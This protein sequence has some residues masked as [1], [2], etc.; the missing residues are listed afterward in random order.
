[1]TLVAY[2]ALH[3]VVFARE[4]LTTASKAAQPDRVLHLTETSL[5]G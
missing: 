1:M 5:P 4:F 2:D 3:A